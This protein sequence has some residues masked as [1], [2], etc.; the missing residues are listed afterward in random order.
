M[1]QDGLYTGVLG[2]DS[3]DVVEFDA[4]FD[5]SEPGIYV[6]RVWTDLEGDSDRS[7][8]TTEVTIVN[9]P[10]ITEYPYTQDFEA[11]N[12]IWYPEAEGLAPSSWE[13]GSPAGGEIA[14]AVSG[15]NAW[16]TN[17]DGPYNDNELSYLNSPCFDLSGFNQDPVIGFHLYLTTQACCDELFLEFS[18]DDGE[19]WE[20]LG[21]SDTGINWYND[22]FNN[23][24][25]GTAGQQGWR[26][27]QHELTDLA[28]APNVRLRFV[29]SSNAG[30][31]EEGA[32]ID[33]IFIGAELDTDLAA[34][35]LALPAGA[36]CGSAEE[37]VR[38][39][40][41]NTGDSPIG[42]PEVSYSVNGGPVVT[43]M[44]TEIV[45][46]PGEQ[47]SYT[48]SQTYD[49]TQ[50]GDYVIKAWG[51]VL[52]D[53]YSGNDTIVQFYRTAVEL[54]FRED[55]EGGSVPE[56]WETSPQANVG[57][58]HNNQSN[59]LFVNM[60][61][62]VSEAF[63]TTPQFGPIQEGDTL[64]FDYKYVD[65]AA[66][67]VPTFLSSGDSLLIEATTD[68]GLTY[69]TLFVIN[70]DNH[71]PN[72]DLTTV[73]LPLDEYAGE[74]LRI[75]FSAVW[76][77][78]DYF[79]DLDN[80]NIR[81]CP[82][83]LGIELELSAASGADN[84]DGSITAT[85]AAGEAPYT[86]EW[87]TGE[88]GAT[89]D[90][91]LPGDYTLTVTDAFGCQQVVTASVS[92]TSTQELNPAA[93]ELSL[94]PNPTSGQTTLN[95]RFPQPAD[96]RILVF[97]AMGQLIYERVEQKVSEGQYLLDLSD[98]S[99]GLYYIQVSAGGQMS[100]AKLIRTNH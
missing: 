46:L 22:A 10:L 61:S 19:N 44:A 55:F 77:A 11:D 42:S 40:I 73:E 36:A 57:S 69:D 28:G 20:R 30:I 6:F 47:D 23:W 58:G 71:L 79:L 2:T 29:F 49:A 31:A 59:V 50:P 99:A 94:A 52:N 48:F 33:N 54:P 64:R 56:G 66:G 88:T 65:F 39:T 100:T 8:D 18:T 84:A 12:G 70:E 5:T 27:V 15:S 62:F 97:N 32:A 83:D 72:L 51:N 9:A 3:T 38:I 34:S 91:L 35:N 95:V 37:S 21:S 26:Y 92:I 85:A 7:N 75:R 63:F 89:I 82:E 14:N 96:A 87:E 45:L 41:L 90:S 81:R 78:G 24:W 67:T 60:Y 98:Q 1:P 93:P 74:F 25:D 86:F 13:Y 4:T 16:V 80:I 43:E 53:P 17:L 76:G 68:C